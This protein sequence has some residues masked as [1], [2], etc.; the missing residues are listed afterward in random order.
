MAGDEQFKLGM[1]KAFVQTGLVPLSGQVGDSCSD[2]H[3]C[4]WTGADPQGKLA[5]RAVGRLVGLLK[6]QEQE[7]MSVGDLIDDSNLMHVANDEGDERDEDLFEEDTE[8]E[9][10]DELE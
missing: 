1:Q 2:L 8:D 3:F 4:R 5:A 6:M 7:M 10:D 9:G